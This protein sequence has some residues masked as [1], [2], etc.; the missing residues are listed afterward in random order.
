MLWLVILW[1]G[2]GSPLCSEPRATCAA[3]SSQ[4]AVGGRK[5]QEALGPFPA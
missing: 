2:R 5:E 1:E 3:A 4:Q